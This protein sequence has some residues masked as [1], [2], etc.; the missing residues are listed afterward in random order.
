M[1][2]LP[3]LR[4]Q[5]PEEEHTLLTVKRRCRKHRKNFSHEILEGTAAVWAAVF[6]NGSPAWG[7]QFLITAAQP[8]YQK[9]GFE[10]SLSATALYPLDIIPKS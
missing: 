5:M 2:A 9:Y 4:I 3:N 10:P 8:L 7:C 6:L 1:G